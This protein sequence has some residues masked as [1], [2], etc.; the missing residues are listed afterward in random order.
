MAENAKPVDLQKLCIM[1]YGIYALGAVL[2]T[3][4]DFLPMGLSILIL[5]VAGHFTKSKK[6]AAEGTAYASHLRWLYRTAWIASCVAIPVNLAL[7]AGLIWIFTDI[8]SI[9]DKVN[10]D[11]DALIHAMQNYMQNNMTRIS[12]FGMMGAAPPTLWWLHRCWRGYVLAK[13]GK[14]V[15]KVTSW[16]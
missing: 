6:D 2:Q 15:E 11:P 10:G 4:S 5:A 12:I 1:L 16:L 14:P 7:S 3:S 8:G 9:A 13:Q